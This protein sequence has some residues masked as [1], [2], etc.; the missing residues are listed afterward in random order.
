MK[1]RLLFLFLL[2]PLTARL[3]VNRLPLNG[4]WEF[5]KSGDTHWMKA[6]VPGT[7]HTDLLNNGKI[8]DP[9]DGTNEKEVQWIENE[10]WEYHCSFSFS[11]K[12][13][14]GK[15]AELVFEG[16][17]TYA[18]VFLNE[19]KILSAANMFRSWRVDVKEK[20]KDGNNTIRVLFYSAVK[21]GKEAAAKLPYT[22]PG[23]EKVFTRKAQYQFGWDWGPRLVTCGVWKPVYLETWEQVRISEVFLDYELTKNGITGDLQVELKGRPEKD[24]EIVVADGETGNTIAVFKD[25]LWQQ[26]DNTGSCRIPVKLDSVPVWKENSTRLFTFRV[27]V[28]QNRKQLA[29]FDY[30][31]GFRDLALV[32][33]KDAAGES[34]YFRLNGKPLFIKGANWIPADNFLPRMTAARYRELLLAAKA[35]NI[36]MLRVWGGGV[37]EDDIFYDLCDSLG[38]LVWQ[39]FMYA[40]AMYPGDTDFV[41]N[42]AAE[43]GEQ[44]K[45]LRHH[46]C[47]ALWCGNNEV[48]EGWFNWGWQKQYHYSA[49]DS[50]KIWQH[51]RTLTDTL[52]R[53]AV[54]ENCRTGYWPSSPSIGWGHPESLESGDAHYWGVWWGMEPFSMY[55]KKVGRFMSEY[56]FQGIPGM[57]T[58]GQFAKEKDFDLQS[59]V[60]KQHQKH[61]TGY[62]TIQTYLAR[63]YRQPKDFESYVYVSQLLQARGM[64]TAIEAHRRA[65]PYCMGTMYWQFNDCWPV[66]SW[67]GID[68]YGRWKALQYQVKRSY[69]SL[70]VSMEV[71]Q[72]SLVF[73]ICN[74]SPVSIPNALF[75]VLA[76]EN[77]GS[78]DKNNGGKKIRIAAEAVTRY[79]I[80]KK[81]LYA[82]GD[83]STVTIVSAIN[84]ER[85]LRWTG[86]HFLCSPK[87]LVLDPPVLKWSVERDLGKNEFHI[88]LFSANLSKDVFIEFHGTGIK[89]SDNFFDMAPSGTKTVYFKSDLS[90]K[91]LYERIRIRTLRDTYEGH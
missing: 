23:D 67:S 63:D 47:I 12:Q 26:K 76:A 34:F 56:G 69:Q 22:L 13:N 82:E 28:F 83:T 19:E 51:Y 2:L 45:R 18:D 53:Y 77:D 16:L 79:A 38:I 90:M 55:E 80:A 64:R 30:R 62:E 27:L 72:D 57:Q 43:A 15:E 61:P 41:A 32:R 74:D 66:T 70:T 31:T 91:E 20:L 7:V 40:C 4:N 81:E 65:R 9:Y 85:S 73:Y 54:G 35:S 21:K 29:S 68:Y 24:Y 10:D 87:N 14:S 50:A 58:I 1:N 71:Q 86:T 39:D 89:L 52:L 6:Q 88:K 46:P 84:D 3:Q 25:V 42:A 59:P 5:R 48:S 33:E 49:D 36:N 44:V 60:M 8:R 37:Y 78:G 17:D 11:K 75:S